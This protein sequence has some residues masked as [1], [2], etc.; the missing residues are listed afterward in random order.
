MARTLK[1]DRLLFLVTLL[2]VGASVVMVYSASAVSGVSRFDVSPEYFLYKQLRWAVMG[3]LL[4]F[5]V[6]K[7]DYHEFGRP[8]VVWS[9]I[10]VTVLLLLAVLVMGSEVNGARRWIRLPGLG[11]QLQPSELA[12]LAAIV[13]AAAVLD[14]RM[15]RIQDAIY[16]LAP[17]AVMT[18]MMTALIL[19]EKDLG[20][21]AVLLLVVAAM[22]FA[23]GM[24]VGHLVAAG[25]ILLPAVGLAIALEPFRL[26]RV[27]DFWFAGGSYQLKQSLLAIGSG[28]VAGLGLNGGIQKL[29]YLP[30]A[31]TDFIF[32][33]IGEELGLIGTTLTLG[34]FIFIAW[35]G[36]RVSLLAPDRFGALLAL[37]ITM[38]IALQAFLNITVVTGFAPTKGLPLPFLSNGGSSLLINLIAMGIL[39][40]VSQQAS[41]VSAVASGPRTRWMLGGQE[42]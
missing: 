33:V 39:L 1:S 12:K 20:T 4:M 37:G 13:F 25:L 22:L 27:T 7:V 23:A 10:V 19:A 8:A 41:P 28:G 34:C 26:K 17:I 35:R 18:G 31:P 15:H 40:N 5:L 42:A 11:L 29:L 30:E 2:L 38:M 9:L 3:F 6:M 16:A 24:R 36:L 32:A 21:S 14:R